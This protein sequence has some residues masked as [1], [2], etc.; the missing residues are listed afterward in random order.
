MNE[1]IDID[2]TQYACVAGVDEAGRGPLVGCVV[3]AAVILDENNPVEGLNDSKKLTAKKREQLAAEIKSRAVAWAVSSV[4]P[5]VI[6]EINILQASLLAMKQ[7][8]EGLPELPDIA[9]IDGNKTPDVACHAHAIVKGD[10]KVASIAAASILA[11][12]E[13]DQQMSE[14]HQVYPQY[15]FERHKGYPTKVHMALLEEHGP[16]PE[17]RRSFGPVKRL[18]V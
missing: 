12:V 3:A 1:D 10:G 15:E 16:C 2:L 6:D 18:L 4:G 7:A 11:K 5:D 14:L 13:R 9:L 17:H 8:L